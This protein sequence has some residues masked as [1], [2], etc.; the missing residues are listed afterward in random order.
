MNSA[1]YDLDEDFSSDAVEQHAEFGQ[2]TARYNLLLVKTSLLLDAVIAGD[3][4]A[5]DIAR[6]LTQSVMNGAETASLVTTQVEAPGTPRQLRATQALD[7]AVIAAAMGR[8]MSLPPSMLR[9]LTTAA[10]LHAVG[11][12]LLPDSLQDEL[13]IKQSAEFSD[14]MQYPQLGAECIESCGG[15]SPVVAQLVSQHRE[16][17]DGTGFPMRMRES[18]FHRHASIIGAVREYQMRAV[19]NQSV[20]PAAALARL[21]LGLRHAYGEHVV[22]SLIATLTVYPPGSFLALSDGSIGRVMKVTHSARL[23]PTVWIYEEDHEPTKA[24]VVDL[25]EKRELSVL[26]VLDPEKLAPNV[27]KFFG[28]AW[29]GVSFQSVA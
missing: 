27:V 4:K 3:F 11:I 6:E 29:G 8:R 14:F 25:A 23:K 18:Q 24:P 15:F 16:R 1:L 26:C 28:G 21:Y 10:L 19:R 12:D 2:T 20:M 22:D 9:D 17:L 5:S 13:A 7:A